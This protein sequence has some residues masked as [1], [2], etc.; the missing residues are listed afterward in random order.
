MRCIASFGLLLSL[1]GCGGYWYADPQACGVVLAVI[2]VP[3]Q[4]TETLCGTAQRGRVRA[5]WR[6][7][8]GLIVLSDALSKDDL[9]CAERHERKHAACW[10]H[11][12]RPQFR[13]DCGE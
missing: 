10:N 13:I 7:N 2:V 4:E 3:Q 1:A 9:E 5:C 6:K 12:Q 11:D 8:D